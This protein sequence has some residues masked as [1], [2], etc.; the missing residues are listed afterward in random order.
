LRPT[1]TLIYF[2][3]AWNPIVKKIEGDYERIT[4]KYQQYHHIKVDCDLTPPVK[5]YFDA[6]VEPQ[7]LILL[8]GAKLRRVIGY[9][10]ERLGEFLE[11]TTE[12]HERDFEYWGDSKDAWERFYDGF[13]RWAREGEHDQ[14]ATRAWQEPRNDQWRGAGTDRP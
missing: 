7:F 12:L 13:D 3:A 4:A 11:H 10:F 14:D 5:F 1:Y 9:N 2:A 6:R 8:N